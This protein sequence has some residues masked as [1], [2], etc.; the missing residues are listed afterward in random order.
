MLVRLFLWYFNPTHRLRFDRHLHQPRLALLLSPPPVIQRGDRD[1]VPRA[2]LPPRHPAFG[3]PVDDAAD[4]LLA[5]HPVIFGSIARPIKTGS[6]DAYTTPKLKPMPGNP[7]GEVHIVQWGSMEE[8]GRE[9]AAYVKWLLVERKYA[10]GDTLVLSPRRMIGYKIRDELVS[11]KI[12]VHSFYHEEAL[13]EEAA[14]LSFVEL[15]LLAEPEDR[16]ALRYWVGYGSPSWRKGEYFKLRS[17][18]EQAGLSPRE[19]LEQQIAGRSVIHGISGLLQRYKTL[20]QELTQMK[21][22]KGC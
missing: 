10:P 17:Y 13:E 9:I 5:S 7:A 1:V 20:Q 21:D 14:Q 12:A 18:C 22:L 6:S 8:E 2:I 19:A 4:F 3:E 16:V 11:Q 15:S